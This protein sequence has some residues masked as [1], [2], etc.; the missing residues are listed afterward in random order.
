MKLL[1]CHSLYP[2]TCTS[3]Y[4]E[5]QLSTL[6]V[7]EHKDGKLA[8]STLNTVSAANALGTGDLTLLVAG[9]AIQPVTQA[10]Q[11]IAC[12]HKILTAQHEA[13]G[14]QLAE[15]WSD[16]LGALQAKSASFCSCFCCCCWSQLEHARLLL[17]ISASPI[18]A[19]SCMVQAQVLTYPDALKHIWKKHLA[20]CCS[21]AGLPASE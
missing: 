21:I 4:R 15:P 18:P 17:L 11:S 1:T 20:T 14:H 12:V 2:S 16:L 5:V 13:L 7:A 9:A 10:A 3:V 6:V 8:P 19:T